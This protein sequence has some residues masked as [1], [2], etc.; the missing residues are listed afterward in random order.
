M[1]TFS[2]ADGTRLGYHER[3]DGPPLICLP[4]GPMQDSEYLGD[5]GGLPAY[6]K[7]ILA[8]P[9]GTGLSA[10]P[11]DPA[12]C[13]CDR[14]V[15][16]VEALRVHLGLDRIDLLGHSAGAN[17]AV[18]YLERYPD[19]VSRLV[20]VTPSP[21]AVGIEITGAARLAAAV[22][23]SDE[24]WYPGAFAALR[25]LVAGEESEEL[26]DQVRPFFYGR[27]DAAARA[28]SEGPYGHRNEEA[29]PFY[30][31]DG[32]FEPATTRAALKSFA[33]P[34][35]LVAGE[36]DLNTM[37]W[38]VTEYAALFPN[39]TLVVQPGAGHY[40]WLDDPERFVATIAGL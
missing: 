16:D 10:M 7:L 34:V 21:R 19:R 35:L 25:A 31:A 6:Q 22:L 8:D 38:A 14:Q 40:P 28:H 13:R 12:S 15:D 30:L 23:R 36:F 5:L 39:A 11:A 26:A 20:L 24:P 17:L 29:I 1:P 37:P 4:G 32:A 18:R 33:A 2:S 27:W 3:G 9:R